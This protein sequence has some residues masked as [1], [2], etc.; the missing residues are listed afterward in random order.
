[1]SDAAVSSARSAPGTATGKRRLV[2]QNGRFFKIFGSANPSVCGFAAATSPTGEAKADADFKLTNK[3]EFS[4]HMGGVSAARLPTALLQWGIPKGEILY[5]YCNR[6]PEIFPP[7]AG[8]VRGASVAP[9]R[10][11][12]YFL[13]GEKVSTFPAFPIR[14]LR[15]HLPPGGRY[16]GVRRKPVRYSRTPGDGCP[17]WATHTS[18]TGDSKGGNIV[19]LLQ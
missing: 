9:R 4:I 6:R 10:L 1:M 2:L 16:C 3:S 5:C 12:G 7:L 14:A 8:G 17:Y 13:A 18:A 15:A 11:F 19:L